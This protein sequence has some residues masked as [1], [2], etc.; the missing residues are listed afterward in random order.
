[1]TNE[2]E[3][4]RQRVEEINDEILGLLSERG[5][6]AKKIGEEKSKQGTQV[7]DPQ[8]EKEMLNKLIDANKGPFNDNT[9]KQ[10]FKEIFKASTDLQNL[11]MKNIYMFLVN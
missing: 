7:Y 10:L 4:L 1:M 8:R 9:I 3:N 11:K 2:L 5:D 6:L